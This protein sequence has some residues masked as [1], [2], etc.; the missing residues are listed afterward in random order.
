MAAEQAATM[1]GERGGWEIYK[2]LFINICEFSWKLLPPDMTGKVFEFYCG[3]HRAW[4]LNPCIVR[5]TRFLWNDL[6]PY[7]SLRSRWTM[8][9]WNNEDVQIKALADYDRARDISSDF[10]ITFRQAYFAIQTF[11]VGYYLNVPDSF[12]WPYGR[13]MHI[14]T[15]CTGNRIINMRK[16]EEAIYNKKFFLK[17]LKCCLLIRCIAELPGAEAQPLDDDIDKELLE[18]VFNYTLRPLAFVCEFLLKSIV[19]VRR[20]AHFIAAQVN[21][22]HVLVALSILAFWFGIYFFLTNVF[23]PVMKALVGF[24]FRRSFTLKTVELDQA[25]LE[26][27]T[28]ALN[29]K[30]VTPS[31][32]I[33]EMA[34]PGSA[35]CA[36]VR[37]PVGAIM[38]ANEDTELMA[39]GCFFR[40]KDWLVTAK[41]VANQVSSGLADVY[42]A[43]PEVT[44][45]GST[46]LNLKQVVHV[47]K[48]RFE[49]DENLFSNQSLD[50]FVMKLTAKE[51]TKLNL[52]TVHLKKA[53]R[54]KQT[55]SSAGYVNGVLQSGSG[56]TGKVKHT[57]FL[58]AHTASTLPGFSGSPIFSG[59]SVVGVHIS[60]SKSENWLVRME[61]VIHY[62]PR[63]EISTDMWAQEYLQSYKDRDEDLEVYNED[64]QWMG[65]SRNGRLKLLDE[66]ELIERGMDPTDKVRRSDVNPSYSF[67]YQQGK[68]WTDIDDDDDDNYGYH[69]KSRRNESAPLRQ[70]G[71][72]KAP[73]A[74]SLPIPTVKK[75]R[76]MRL[77]NQA[78]V[79]G[80]RMPGDNADIIDYFKQRK[81]SLDSLGYKAG[82]Y[83][84]PEINP[85]VEEVSLVKHLEMFADEQ[86]KIVNIPTTEERERC[87]NVC[88]DMLRA[89]RFEPM[90]GYK[91]KNNLM[92]II[93]SNLVGARKS[94]GRPYQAEGMPTNGDVLKNI[95]AEGLINLVHERWNEKITLKVFPKSEPNKAKKVERRMIRVVTGFPLHKMV[96]NQAIFRES[97]ETAVQKWKESPIK[98]AFNPGLPGH[99]EHLASCFTRCPVEEADKSNWDFHMFGYIFDLCKEIHIRLA[100]QPAS[101]SDK[102]FEEWKIDA[103]GAYDEV[104]KNIE[105]ACTNGK[106]YASP[107]EGIMKSG[108]LCTIFTNSLGQ[109]VLHVLTMMRCGQTNADILS[110]KNCLVA[111]GDDTMN[112]FASPKLK[113]KYIEE[114]EKLGFPLEF[115]SN[116]GFEGSEFFS[117]HFKEFRGM[118]GFEPV[119][120]TKH[121]EKMGKLKNEHLASALSCAMINYCWKNA[122]FKFFQ[123]MY[124]HFRQK[125]PDNFPLH[126]LIDQRAQQYK[127]KGLEAVGNKQTGD[128]TDLDSLL[129]EHLLA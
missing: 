60:G 46:K 93:N 115:K 85:T 38:V 105:Y 72:I 56:T 74:S 7:E 36:S 61:V 34:M 33:E 117:N 23:M 110:S 43:P 90:T 88:L 65:V 112:S 123:K 37:R 119:R 80:S 116:K 79:H 71:L 12:Y 11:N 113:P 40:Y 30:L 99:I 76:V 97:L 84:W 57:N 6:V 73:D 122:E 45:R 32:Q 87:V 3:D 82:E 29:V 66:D 24:V 19:R 101:M 70:Q 2:V 114:S 21:L 54:Y 52:N 22:S 17:S 108:W 13:M 95:G 28:P 9:P 125:D 51:W 18:I 5:T 35:L 109:V 55:I 50:V 91:E 49:L 102:E 68:R 10:D 64:D 48:S 44:S 16:L 111:G 75:A 53:T 89:N 128:F 94:A 67:D 103:A 120:F 31:I 8:V 59:S 47:D 92:E 41:H 20:F 42:L 81:E 4:V 86:P 83:V 69:Y 58:L 104:Y 15:N 26:S 27:K 118:W 106:V 62:L 100:V 107:F 121:V 126:F 63:D 14:I 124:T 129:D 98:Y 25:P 1:R 127:C 96:K 78:P 77:E 39:V